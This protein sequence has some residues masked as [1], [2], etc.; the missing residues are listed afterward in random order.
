MAFSFEGVN[1]G[2]PTEYSSGE[3]P[4]PPKHKETP[5]AMDLSL[6]LSDDMEEESDISLKI[7]DIRTETKL[8][9]SEEKPLA[10]VE[11]QSEKEQPPVVQKQCPRET[12]MSVSEQTGVTL[13][14]SVDVQCT[15]EQVAEPTTQNKEVVNEKLK[16]DVPEGEASSE[17]VRRRRGRPPKKAKRLQQPEKKVQSSTEV[18]AQK[19]DVTSPSGRVKKVD[20]CSVV[21][22]V[23]TRT[24]DFP[25]TSPVKT[26]NTSPIAS[27]SVQERDNTALKD[28]DNRNVRS[29]VASIRGRSSEKKM[30]ESQLPFIEI[31]EAAIEPPS[32]NVSSTNA[33]P[34]ESQQAASP[35]RRRTSVTL[36]DAMLLV[37]AMSQST[38][39]KDVSSSQRHTASPQTQCASSV[40]TKTADEI[41]TMTDTHLLPDVA[42]DK[43]QL[44]YPKIA[45]RVSLP[46][47]VVQAHLRFVKASQQHLVNSSKTSAAPLPVSSAA[48][49]TAV[50]IPKE[51]LHPLITAEAQHKRINSAPQHYIVVPKSAS[52]SSAISS[53]K[54]PALVS[55]VVAAQ[56]NSLLSVSSAQSKPLGTASLPPV[57]QKIYVTSEK[58]HPPRPSQPTSQP[59]ATSRNQPAKTSQKITII[60]P[61]QSQAVLKTMQESDKSAVPVMT[62][63]PKQTTLSHEANVSLD[64]QT[65]SDKNATLSVLKKD[66]SS[67]NMESLKQSASPCKLSNASTNT[68][69][70]F[71]RSIGKIPAS[72]FSAAQPTIEQKHSAMVRLTRLP[73]PISTKESVFVSRLLSNG[74]SETQTRLT[75]DAQNKQSFV[76]PLTQPSGMLVVST[77][78]GPNLKASS[79]AVSGELNDVQG[80]VSSSSEAILKNL[81]GTTFHPK[82]SSPSSKGSTSVSVES[83]VSTR[84]TESFADESASFMG[85]DIISDAVENEGFP[86]NDPHIEDNK[87][88]APIQLTTVT[89]KDMSDP[90][91]QMTKA[92][93]LAQLAV[94]PVAEPTGKVIPQ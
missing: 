22:K 72:V 1:E 54:R 91:V 52:M 4:L 85:E 94:S 73:F 60:I 25:N 5:E 28:I 90:H 20:V 42:H 9:T 41:P 38:V 17:P 2:S 84:T 69:S 46:S 8:I 3:I 66:S 43:V 37:G 92:Q 32:S 64:G 88:A 50:S 55:A 67:E 58:L 74:T 11:R 24:S 19:G 78:T 44:S 65:T 51:S 15:V 33:P 59:S 34:K 13:Q 77:S 68:D 49:T 63:S 79:I 40:C 56:N 82:V 75:E 14:Q 29:A 16:T 12:E 71:K 18:A 27:T 6:S 30:S 10:A 87:S 48:Q 76:V 39:E 70:T 57:L 26:K 83:A 61:R 21:D 7:S 86:P 53:A 45:P 35:G 47:S 81:Q 93:F 62:E 80:N 89:S 23:N 36:Q 31:E